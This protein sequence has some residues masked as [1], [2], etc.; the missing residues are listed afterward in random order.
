MLYP[1][2]DVFLK[3]L[4]CGFRQDQKLVERISV[5]GVQPRTS[6][7]IID[8]LLPQIS[9][10]TDTAMDCRHQVRLEIKANTSMSRTQSDRSW[11]LGLGAKA[12]S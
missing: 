4:P 5:V 10:S 12:C 2:Y 3:G 9:L 11:G 1:H 8:L 7:G 6:K